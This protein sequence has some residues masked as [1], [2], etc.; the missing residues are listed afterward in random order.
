[1]RANL[2]IAI[3]KMVVKS[4][5]TN[6]TAPEYEQNDLFPHE[7]ILCENRFVK[8]IDSEIH[9]N[10][11]VHKANTIS[12]HYQRY[13]VNDDFFFLMLNFFL[14]FVILINLIFGRLLIVLNGLKKCKELFCHHFIGDTH[15][16]IFLA[17]S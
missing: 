1:M 5:S 17:V 6:L 11:I 15:Y 14:L 9:V 13:R 8:N 12:E 4:N 7:S 3:T 10:Q 16:H 2:A